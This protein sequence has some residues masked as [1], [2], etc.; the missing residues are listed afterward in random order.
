MYIYIHT[1]YTTLSMTL[2]SFH[3]PEAL[4]FD[5]G[6]AVAKSTRS[7]VEPGP[8]L[9]LRRRHHHT[10]RPTKGIAARAARATRGL[11][12]LL[13]ELEP[14]LLP[15]EPPKD[16][17]VAAETIDKEVTGVVVNVAPLPQVKVNA[18]DA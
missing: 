18:D 8:R 6:E 14:P 3:R 11:D 9:F 2:G 1:C 10:A 7:E 13:L 4:R 17:G 15:V 12:V 5:K 16:V